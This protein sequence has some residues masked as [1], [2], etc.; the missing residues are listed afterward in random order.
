MDYF[1]HGQILSKYDKTPDI[2]ES[3]FNKANEEG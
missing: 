2:I 1:L 3:F